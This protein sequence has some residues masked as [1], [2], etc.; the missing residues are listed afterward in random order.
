MPNK[1]NY[2]TQKRPDG[3]WESKREGAERASKV[4]ATQAEAWDAS[5]NFAK[6]N[7]GEAILKGRDGRIRDRNTYG[8]D[9]YP[10]K[11]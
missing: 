5:K 11:G 10:P 8:N 1:D 7:D 4:T 2:W 9:P 6:Q 3:R